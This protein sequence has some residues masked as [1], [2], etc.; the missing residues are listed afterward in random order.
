MMATTSAR[1]LSSGGWRLYAGVHRDGDSD[2]G[3]EGRPELA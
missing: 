2:V 3:G 1:W